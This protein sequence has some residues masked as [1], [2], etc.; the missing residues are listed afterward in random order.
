MDS[1]N[2]KNLI[3]YAYE[4]LNLSEY[5]ELYV[6]NRL[7]E[8]CFMEE[9]D[10]ASIDNDKLIDVVGL[11]YPDP[12]INP[13]LDDLISSGKVSNSNR[14]YY[15]C[16]IMDIIS[17]K[18][19]E[20]ERTFKEI[21]TTS[22]ADAFKWLHSYSEHNSYIKLSDIRKNLKWEVN[23]EK[24]GII[25]TINLSKPEKS[26]SDVKKALTSTPKYP[27]CVICPENMGYAGHGTTRQNLRGHNITLGGDPWFWQ[28]SPYAY[29]NE[30]GIAINAC[31]TPMV[32]EEKNITNVLDFLDYVPEYFIGFNAALP[33]VG[34]SILAHDHYQGGRCV[35]PMFNSKDRYLFTSKDYPN[36]KISILNWYNSVIRLESK[37]REEI[38][39]LGQKI[40]TAWKS[41]DDV[42][43]GIIAKTIEQHN[44]ITCVSRYEGRYIVDLILRNNM[45]SDNYPDGIYHAHPEYHNIKK[46]AIGLIEAGG[47][48]I[49][50]A[51]LKRQLAIVSDCLQGLDVNQLQEDM[52]VHKDMI[53]RLIIKHGTSNS[54]EKANSIVKEEIER[55][56]R[57]ILKNTAVYK[58]TE[59]GNEG[60]IEFLCSL[61]LDLV[62]GN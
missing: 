49:L 23:D 44:S 4:H 36:V 50:P 11:D 7:L 3:N 6:R 29:F 15:L 2:I 24:G 59:K 52:L 45:T 18:P 30:H 57:E 46:E 54:L 61:N 41:Y 37:S 43:N 14:E 17:L 33:I 22:T 26:I 62:G 42:E 20:V 21:S 9:Y 12:I 10:E 56:C 58:E 35:L 25:I 32:V 1:S 48:F 16:K 51:R 5:D 31:H 55:I 19:S 27:K 47:M 8:A 40:V 34:G 53:D 60:F 38:E 13:I 39:A 28:F